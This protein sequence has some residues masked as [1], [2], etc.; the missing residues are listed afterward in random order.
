MNKRIIVFAPHPDD[1]TF[2]CGGTIAKRISEGYEVI[3]VVITDGRHAYSKVLGINSD[4]T[5]EELKE[6]RKE[7]LIRATNV[8]GVPKKNL[9]FLDFEDGTLEK[10]EKEAKE[11]II[12][13]IKKYSPVEVYFPYIKDY[14]PDHQATNRIIRCIQKLGLTSM[15][16]QYSI[17]QK[18]ARIGP[19][20]DRLI[21]LFNKNMIEVDIAEFINLKEKAVKEFK[22]EISIIS[23]KQ[24]KPITENIDKFLRNKEIFYVDKCARTQKIQDYPR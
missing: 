4:P 16:Y 3:I 23:T 20:A 10:Y 22:S 18:Y 2:G 21:N 14:N 24:K 8:L 12:E 11:K 9:L 13:I 5:P 17:T 7:E 1:E 6:I 15:E 19:L